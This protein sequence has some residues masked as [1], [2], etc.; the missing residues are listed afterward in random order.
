M[1]RLFLAAA[2]LAGWAATAGSAGA[3][4][5]PGPAPGK[6]RVRHDAAIVALEND[7]LS[8]AWEFGAAGPRCVELRNLAGGQAI[9]GRTRP[10]FVLCGP[11][12]KSWDASQFKLDTNGLRVEAL[13]PVAGG[14]RGAERFGG[15]RVSARLVATQADLAVAWEA[16][17][18]DGANYVRQRWTITSPGR[19]QSL[20]RVELLDGDCP[21]ARVGGE[22]PM[23]SN[24]VES[25][26]IRCG[27]GAWEKLTAG[28]ACRRSCVAGVAPPGQ[29]RRAFLYYIERERPRPYAPFLH[30]NSWYDIAWGDR[31]MNEAQCL[32]V[33][34]E[35]RRELIQGRGAVLDSVVF[36][37]GWDDNRTLWGF[38]P[39][40]PRGFAPLAD[41]AAKC[42][43]ALGVWLSPWGGYGTAQAE[44]L[45][46]GATQGF[47]TNRPGF[48]LAGPKYYARFREVCL[49]MIRKYKV[50]Y[51]KF[52]GIAQGSTSSGAGGEFAADVDGLLRLVGDLRRARPDVFVSI[53]TGTWPS[54]YWLFWGDSVWR[55]ADDMGFFGPGSRRQ[56]W[57]T[58]RDM[59]TY[60]W[61]VRRAPL[62]P[63]NS[64]MTQGICHSRVGTAAEMTPDLKDMA[65][66]I[67]SFFA[68]GTHLQELYVQP[69]RLTP[70]MWDLLAEGAKWS[71]A[72]AA[73]LVDVHWIGG[74]PGKGEVYGEASWSPAKGIVWLR[75]PSTAPQTFSLD[76]GRALELPDGAARKFAVSAPWRGAKP[77]PV[78]ELVAGRAQ[79]ISLEPFEVLVLEVL[80]RR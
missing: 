32:A 29:M 63:L 71:R 39:G 34:E 74:D 64:L 58:Y 21:G 40:F 19:T 69:Q 72:N 75:N 18:R 61:I 15:H 77:A 6:A 78:A 28:D 35:F 16:E 79:P 23:A 24:R 48:S 2:W 9:D 54:P 43:T 7:L 1:Q 37:D 45:R 5:Y 20:S 57:I 22:H 70:A 8:A 80:P 73:T 62:Y 47:E 30:Y 56:Q 60:R 4:D 17:L 36:D 44:R 10:W 66:E 41:A 49:D 33:I 53:T 76:V 42:N 11:N 55:N 50:N 31:K 52:D 65:D 59:I 27:V 14:L 38:H 25:G 68:T 67:R 13:A 46:Y 51:F 12:D 3:V 26:R